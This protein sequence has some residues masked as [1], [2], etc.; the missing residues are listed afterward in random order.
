MELLRYVHTQVKS[1]GAE[2]SVQ[3]W[4]LSDGAISCWDGHNWYPPDAFEL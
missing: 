3:V 2:I 4:R 1:S